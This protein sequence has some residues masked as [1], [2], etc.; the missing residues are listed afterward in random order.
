MYVNN[1]PFTPSWLHM[2]ARLVQVFVDVDC[3]QL[4]VNPL[5]ETPQGKV[6]FYT[7]LFFFILV[8]LENFKC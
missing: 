3:T 1:P 4:E 5:A 6:G 8:L 2:K 7:R